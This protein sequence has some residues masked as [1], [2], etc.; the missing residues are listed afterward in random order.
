MIEGRPLVANGRSEIGHFESDTIVGAGKQ[1]AIMTYVCR[2][3]RLLI[4]E[5]MKD[6][7]ASTFNHF[8]IEN[9]KY[10]PK[11]LIKTFTSDSGEEFSKFKEHKKELKVNSYF[12]NS[13]NSC[14]RGTNKNTNS[15]LSRYFP[16]GTNFSK[17][18]KKDMNK[19]EEP[20]FP[21]KTVSITT[22]RLGLTAAQIGKYSK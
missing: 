7:K 16:K 14:E 19:A 9:Y 2:K 20:G 4:V 18:T 8:T 3:L 15:F 17:L 21:I 6:R 1:D 13:Y 10:I 12:A 11:K 5:L 22:R